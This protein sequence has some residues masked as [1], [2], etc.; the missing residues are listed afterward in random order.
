[1]NVEITA[2]HKN[3]IVKEKKDKFT[4]EISKELLLQVEQK[5]EL[6][7]GQFQFESY[8]IPVDIALHKQYAEKKYGDIIKV[9]CNI[10]A[11]AISAEF[12]TLGI[13][14]AK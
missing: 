3:L 13:S 6:P 14:K 5:K 9:P 8:D 12:A 4:G 11:K 7:D 1:M 2:I 10:Y